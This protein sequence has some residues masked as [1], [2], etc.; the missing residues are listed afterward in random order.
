MAPMRLR[1]YILPTP[2]PTSP[3]PRV[4]TCTASGKLI[5]IRRHG[6]S[7]TMMATASGTPDLVGIGMN[8]ADAAASAA[9]K[10]VTSGSHRK[11]MTP[12]PRST[13]ASMDAGSCARRFSFTTIMLPTAMPSSTTATIALNVL[14]R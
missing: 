9:E 12:N 1:A 7:M 4:W 10:L 8:A 13:F 6:K 2:S 11:P 3:A 5:P 14:A